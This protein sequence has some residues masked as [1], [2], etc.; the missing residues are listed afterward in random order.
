LIINMI[1]ILLL[2]FIGKGKPRVAFDRKITNFIRIPFIF[3]II[4]IIWAIVF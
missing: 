1:V 2:V 3:A 4:A